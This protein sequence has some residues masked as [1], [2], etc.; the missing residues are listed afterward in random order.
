MHPVEDL[1]KRFQTA[2][3]E[4]QSWDSIL[5][6]AYRYA[7]PG[8]ERFYK[9]HPGDRGRE[10]E[11]FDNTAVYGTTAFASRVQS[12]LMPPWRHW[13]KLV[14]GPEIDDEDKNDLE[15]ALDKAT[16]TLFRHF[17]QSTLDMTVHEALQDMAISTGAILFQEGDRSRGEPL[18]QFTSV[19]LAHLYP[20]EGAFG[21]LDG[22]WRT[23]ELPVR[24]IQTNW[25]DAKLSRDLETKKSTN[26]DDKVTL[27]EGTIPDDKG[28]WHYVVIDEDGKHL[29]V[30]RMLKDYPWILFRWNKNPGEKLG[31][32][33]V[34]SVLPEIQVLNKADEFRLR[35][36]ALAIGGVYTAR[37]D[38]VLNPY[39]VQLVPNTIIPVGSNDHSNPSIAPLPLSGDPKLQELFMEERR[40]R[41][42]KALMVDPFGDVDSPVKSATEISLR[43]Q[44]LAQQVGAQFGR[45][46]SEL[47]VPIVRRALAILENNGLIEPIELDGAKVDLNYESPL[48]RMQDQ[49]DMT[50]LMQ[51]MEILTSLGQETLMM[52]F[53]IEDLADEIGPKLGVP[54]DMR[55]DKPEREKMMQGIQQMVAQFMAEQQMKAQEAQNGTAPRA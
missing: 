52:N 31:R 25:R 32:G 10:S 23:V 28:G 36:A 43:Q 50:G 35:A 45:L 38:G 11:I 6:D 26:P 19:P 18:F 13:C 33:P 21:K 44:E 47:L 30:D 55:R 8:R 51:Y 49:E 14:P 41:V 24:A 22:C 40:E 20:E 54:A 34:I 46:Q 15:D 16:E 7:V 2:K 27:V 17:H 29:V 1:I 9:R 48:A 3:S 37:N 4:R 53:K 12:L 42:R 5:H 39:N